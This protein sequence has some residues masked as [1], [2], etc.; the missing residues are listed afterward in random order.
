VEVV[1]TDFGG[2]L[3]PPIA[4]TFAL[5]VAAVGVPE[6][7]FRTAIDAVA[8]DFGLHALEPM[9]RGLLT[10][11]EWGRRVTAALAP[12]WRPAIDL[13]HFGDYWYAGR[14]LNR[15]L[16]DRLVALKQRGLRIGLL[17]NSIREWEPHRRAMLPDTTLFDARINSFE[18]GI[19]KPDP[20][21]YSLAEVALGVAGSGC[22]LIDDLPVNCAAAANR[23]WHALLHVTNLPTLAELG[24][25]AG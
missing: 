17:T 7:A 2:V 22:L 11:S 1:W 25:L 6:Q 4:E 3:T 5:V 15:A 21:I 20:D 16:Y 19:G 14:V 18:A 24:R 23:G 8:A 9:E 10:Q 13:A 12:T